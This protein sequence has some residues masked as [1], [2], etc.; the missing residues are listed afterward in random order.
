M[1]LCFVWNFQGQSKKSKNSRGLFKDVC[2][3]LSGITHFANSIICR[4]KNAEVL[5]YYFLYE[6][7][8]RQIFK[9]LLV[10]LQNRVTRMLHE[11]HA[12]LESHIH[13]KFHYCVLRNPYFLIIRGFMFLVI[14]DVIRTGVKFH[15]SIKIAC[16]HE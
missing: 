13:T 9:S 12:S 6:H 10:Y 1:K 5:G 2:L 11:T 14:C 7:I 3:Q 4:I 15:V 16:F 8:Y